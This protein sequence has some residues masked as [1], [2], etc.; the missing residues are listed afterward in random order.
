MAKKYVF[1]LLIALII[2][3]MAGLMQNNQKARICFKK[4]CFEVEIAQTDRE[5]KQGLMFRK[6]LAQ[7]KGML[8]IFEQEKEHSFWLKNTLI[9]LDIIWLDENQR[10]V[11]IEKNALP[12]PAQEEK[13]QSIK[14]NKK[15]KYVLE[16]NAGLAE[17]IN[18]QTGDK[19]SF[20]Q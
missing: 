12:C 7:D 5:R 11:F 2:L 19:L 18:L 10:V 14:P 1:L 17:K 9:P 4:H 16:I 8:F 6:K 3:I 20:R 15:A 13:C